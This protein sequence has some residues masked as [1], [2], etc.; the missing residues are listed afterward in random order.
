MAYYN[1]SHYYDLATTGASDAY[2]LPE[3]PAIGEDNYTQ[4]PDSLAI[5]WGHRWSPE[6][7]AHAPS[8]APP[9]S[10]Y[11]QPPYSAPTFPR[12]QPESSNAPNWN[13]LFANTLTLGASDA[14]A[15]PNT[16][17]YLSVLHP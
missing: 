16:C 14:M 1:N 2:P 12:S 13:G 7:V 5:G 3:M 8:Y 15:V 4:V 17:E 6:T 10:G 11:A 9:V